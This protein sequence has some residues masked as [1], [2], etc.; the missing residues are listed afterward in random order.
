MNR[1]GKKAGAASGRKSTKP[2]TTRDKPKSQS[3]PVHKHGKKRSSAPEELAEKLALL[4]DANDAVIGYDSEFRIVFWNEMA[5]VLYGYSADEAIGQLGY[6]LLKPEYPNASRDEL[7]RKADTGGRFVAESVRTAKDERRLYVDTHVLARRSKQGK[8]IGYLAV[9]RDITE[10]KA[11]EAQLVRLYRTLN[12]LRHSSEAIAKTQGEKKFLDEVCK[13]IVEDCGHAM[14]WIG[15]KEDDAYKSV[16]P[17]AFSGFE[18]GYLETLKITWSDTERGRGPTGTAVRTGEPSL[19]RNMQT[20]PKFNPWREQATKRGYSSSISIPLFGEQEVMGA[21]TIYSKEPD[22]FTEDELRF[23][24]ELADDLAYGIR[25]IRLREVHKKT[26]QALRVSEANANALIKYAPTAIYEIDF[27]QRRFISINEVMSHMLGY[28]KEE[29]LAIDPS[30]LLD[31]DSRARFAE[32]IRKQ[33]S[34]ERIDEAVEYRAFRK[35]GTELYGLL[36]VSLS[37]SSGRPHRALVVAYDIT[38]RK[39]MEARLKEAAEKYSTL[40]NSTSDGV[41]IHNMDGEIL[42]VNDAYCRMSGYSRE[43]LTHMSINELEAREDHAE[44]ADHIRKLT[45]KGGHDRFESVHRRKDGTSFDADISVLLLP[46]DDGRIAIFVRDIT[47]KKKTEEAVRVSREY[48]RQLVENSGGIILRVDK[49]MRITFIN[50]FGLQ[51]FGYLPE[52]IIGKRAV[53]TI[54]PEQAENGYDTASMAEDIIRRPDRYST[55]VHQNMRKD[56]SLVWVSWANR[57][58]Y[59]SQ[60]NLV[61]ILSIGNDLSKQKEAEQALKKSEM[62]FRL[63][64]DIGGRL[65]ASENPQEIVNDL[66]SQVMIFLDCQVFF[67]YLVN[68]SASK[69]EI[70]AYAGIPEEEADKIRSID[71]GVA[72]CGAVARD[73]EGIIAEDI[74]NTS[75]P[76]AQLVRQ[77]GIL[78]YCC[79]PLK[80]Q[81]KVIGTLS[82]GS[83]KRPHFTDDEVEL[84]RTVADQVAAAMQRVESE[85][86]ISRAAHQW[87][88]TFDSI[89]DMVSIQGKDY[90]LISVNKAYE[91]T[92]NMSS[93]ELKG[94]Q[95]FEIVHHSNCPVTNCPHNKTLKTEKTESE[96]IYEPLLNAYLEVTASPLFDEDGELLGT[97]HVAKDVTARKKSEDELKRHRE[98]LEE[99]VAEKT[100]EITTVNA[101]NRS[102][103]EV[104]LD[105][106]VTISAQ[107]KLTDVNKAV[108]LVT[109]VPRRD[110]IGS[111]FS[112]YFTDPEKAEEGYKR[113]LSEGE[114]L[115]YPL[116]IRHVSGNTTDVLYNATVYRDEKGEIQGVFAA[117]RDV[118]EINKAQEKQRMLIA[119]LGRS[120]TELEQFA[121]VASHD[122]QEP[123]RMISSYTQLLAR[124]YEGKLDSDANEFIGFAVDGAVRM[125][126]LINSLLTYSRVGR[127]GN[128]FSNVDSHVVVAEAIVNL[129]AAVE[130]SGALIV[131]DDL[132]V[133]YGDEMQLVQLFQN[134]MGNS[135]KF[136]SDESPRVRISAK[137]EGSQ[138]LFS[139]SDN[140]I[141]IDPQYH[142]RVFVIFQRLHPR[143]KYAGTGMGLAICKKIVERHGGK[144]WFESAPGKG[145]TFFFTIPKSK[146]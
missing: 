90:R 117:A 101:Y 64:S 23:L 76:R 107:G 137:E 1:V 69:L 56:G 105:P 113:V 135:I 14:M 55:N 34:G 91:K 3:T 119:E 67:N 12:A 111:S 104:S 71:Y 17:V 96:V 25:V 109:G 100:N 58:I 87:Q 45:E 8:L 5:H 102:L 4:A 136:R 130:E 41:W 82:F 75:D 60:G 121:Y 128:P 72:V 79:H 93:E 97:V 99:L 116:T 140:G 126:A 123:L 77:Y 13:I 39:Q 29:L 30:T 84:M 38:E 80:A 88:I 89:P 7:L 132:P 26:D 73:G 20:D 51:F 43:E 53:G 59:D 114:V 27:E 112:D 33:L 68:E 61:E 18:E 110:L 115:D 74:Q 81:G 131:T 106:L 48:Y 108:E 19:C 145:S 36:N 138:W 37:P 129:K 127:R 50:N 124:R 70:N 42:E 24:T 95:C 46:N 16:R 47:E 141:G 21:L 32:R 83:R 52:E 28:S 94:R 35:D 10:Q 118:T 122:L 9:D 133:V 146:E 65:L 85:K 120:N 78:A 22:P 63:L 86:K 125:Q 54:I 2:E 143:E 139:V 66:C 31:E 15:Y 103:L 57:P 40:F 62:R 49:D 6:E 142:E 144:I 134:L 11:R 92:F 98:H 44:T